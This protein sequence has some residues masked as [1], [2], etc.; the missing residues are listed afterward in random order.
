MLDFQIK[1]SLEDKIPLFT[2]S[3][4]RTTELQE[5]KNFIWVIFF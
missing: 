1:I 4:L 5:Y 2:K 3:E